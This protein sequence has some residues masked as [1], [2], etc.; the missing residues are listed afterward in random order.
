MDS[1]LQ[2][3][4]NQAV[5][6]GPLS[7]LGVLVALAFPAIMSPGV[8]RRDWMLAAAILGASIG[9]LFLPTVVVVACGAVVGLP[10]S[11]LATLRRRDP[12]SAKVRGAIGV[13]LV[14][15][16]WMGLLVATPC[17]SPYPRLMLPWLLAG[18][19]GAAICWSGVWQASELKLSNGQ[20]RARLS[21]LLALL[22]AAGVVWVTQVGPWN[23]FA[24]PADR[25]GIEKIARQMH[26]IPPHDELRVI[27]AYGEPALYFQLRAARED[28]VAPVQEV[29]RQSATVDGKT[30][31][32]FLIVGPH[33]Q[34]DAQFQEQWEEGQHRFE[35][36]KTFEYEPSAMVWLDLHDPRKPAPEPGTHAVRLYRLKP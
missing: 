12:D 3:L 8:V 33:S 2:Q 34:N 6:E 28:I 36:V 16:W 21:E 23:R 1:A 10:G 11:V 9:A 17:Y 4:A 20:Y 7:K 24:G 31:P 32:T 5:M 27:Y 30:V 19:L 22:V 35:L 13:A 25:R 18:W 26:A 29:P 15:A 14:M